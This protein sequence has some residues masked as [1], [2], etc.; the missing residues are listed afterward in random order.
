M[1]NEEEEVLQTK[2]LSSREIAE[3]WEECL[4][5]GRNEVEFL[6]NKKEAFREMFPEEFRKFKEDAEK[7]GKEIEYI[8]SKLVFTRKSC[9]DGGKKKIRWVARENLE[10]RREE[11]DN[12]SSGADAS[13]LYILVWI[14]ARGQWCAITLDGKIAFLNAKMVQLEDEDLLLV[15]LPYLIIEKKFLRKDVLYKPEKVIYGFRRS[16]KFGGFD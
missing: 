5:A 6:L 11:D 14:A 4:P 7:K 13:A 10:P 16:P 9:L 12:F 15:K 1:P 2:I 3:N 8:P